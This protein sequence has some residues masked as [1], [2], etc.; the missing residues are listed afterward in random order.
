MLV[1]GVGH[2]ALLALEDDRRDLVLEVAGLRGAL[3]AVVAFNGQ[4]VL[5]FTRDAPL[6]GDVLGRH[7]HVNRVERVVQRANHHVGELGVAQAGAPAA[8]QAGVRA[9]AHVLGAAADG[10]VGVTQ[11]DGLRCRHDGLQGRSRTG[12]SR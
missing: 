11:Q 4:L 9:A 6:G 7:A 3:G 8:R 2:V 10:D 5:V 1:G 12:G